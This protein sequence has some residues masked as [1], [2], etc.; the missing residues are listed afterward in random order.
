[1]PLEA[2]NRLTIGRLNVDVKEVIAAFKLDHEWEKGKALTT[3]QYN[4]LYNIIPE[5]IREEH[6]KDISFLERFLQWCTGQR[7]S[8]TQILCTLHHHFTCR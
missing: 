6:S 5:V 2:V 8:W 7:V 1:M 3:D 4:L